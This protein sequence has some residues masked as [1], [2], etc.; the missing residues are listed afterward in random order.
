MRTANDIADWIVRYS[1]DDLGAP[2]D[3]MSLEKLAYYAQAFNLALK[4]EP[5]FA[6]EVQAW[7][8]GPVVPA[9]YKRYAGFGANPI[10]PED[11]SAC[12]VPTTEAAFLAQIAGFFLQHTATNL[13][14]ATHLE[15]PW[16]DTRSEPDPKI[17]PQFEMMSY[18]RLL[19]SEG[20]RALSRHELLDVVPE[21]RWASFYVAGIC[22]RRMT[23][24]PF[25]DGALAKKL[26]ES[27]TQSEKF[28]RSFYAPVSGRD[29]IEFSRDEDPAD[30]IKRALS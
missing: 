5:L 26:G 7:Q 10:L 2:V 18:Y 23:S 28:S 25:Y 4:G 14:R 22:C 20:E 19:M 15:A 16:L 13:S 11:D 30:T 27:V 6:D 3:P 24:H 8:W 29:F 9:V 12:F 17:I 21:P 1:S